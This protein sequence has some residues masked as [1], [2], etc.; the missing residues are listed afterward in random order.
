[1]QN[2]EFLSYVQVHVNECW[3]Q[4]LLNSYLF[5]NLNQQSLIIF[6]RVF[7]RCYPDSLKR[8]LNVKGTN[9]T[10][11][12]KLYILPDYYYYPH[13]YFPWNQ[14]Y[15]FWLRL[16]VKLSPYDIFC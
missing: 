5:N 13:D 3:Y 6:F 14:Q 9:C 11:Q 4:R 15:G 12:T 7:L 10:E 1:M 16:T 2:A 8:G